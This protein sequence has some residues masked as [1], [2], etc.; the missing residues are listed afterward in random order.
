MSNIRPGD[1][2]IYRDG[3]RFLVARVDLVKDRHLTGFPFDPVHRRW[4]AARRRIAR[5]FV[6]DRLPASANTLS[7]A[8]RIE[9]LRNV[10]EMQRQRA[11]RELEQSVRQLIAVAE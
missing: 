7:I 9:C 2:V 6:V 3:D 5:D 11:N 10:R 1:R 4:S 8:A